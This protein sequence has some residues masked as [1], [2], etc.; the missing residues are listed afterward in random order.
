MLVELVAEG[1]ATEAESEF[2]FE[3]LSRTVI[4]SESSTF[5]GN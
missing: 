4:H 1:N 2:R 5:V 3:D